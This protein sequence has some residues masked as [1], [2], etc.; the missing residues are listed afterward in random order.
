MPPAEKKVA[1]YDLV[2]SATKPEKRFER[3]GYNYND[4]WEVC[5]QAKWLRHQAGAD[6]RI[7]WHK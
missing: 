7:Q 5:K 6:L 4:L 1:W 2:L 3:L